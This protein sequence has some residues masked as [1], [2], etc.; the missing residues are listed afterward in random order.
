MGAYLSAT[1]VLTDYTIVFLDRELI[2]PAKYEV[3][4]NEL[5]RHLGHLL[6]FF[7]SGQMYSYLHIVALVAREISPIRLAEQGAAT[8]ADFA[9]VLRN[10]LVRTFGAHVDNSEAALRIA[11]FARTMWSDF[12]GLLFDVH[13]R[14]LVL[15]VRLVQF[16]LDEA[17]EDATAAAEVAE[18]PQQDGE[19]VVEAL[20]E[21]Q[22]D[23]EIVV[24]APEQE[25]EPEEEGEGDGDGEIV[26]EAP[27]EPH[28]D[29][30]GDVVM[31]TQREPEGRGSK[32]RSRDL[33]YEED[34][35]RARE[36]KR[37]YGLRTTRAREE[38]MAKSKDDDAKRKVDDGGGSPSKGSRKRSRR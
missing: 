21:P 13:Q 3:F 23:G 27:P 12:R 37:R 5:T 6:P 17:E 10:V 15:A 7:V 20:P 25:E 36:A 35:A 19:I 4:H 38:R 30:D 32:R 26:I 28:V 29:E 2:D 1:S 16:I 18:V 31:E 9:T 22:Q 24:E 11:M 8:W 14:R 33:S 34:L